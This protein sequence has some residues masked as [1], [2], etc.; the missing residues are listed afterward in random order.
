[1][2]KSTRSYQPELI[3]LGPDFY[4]AEEYDRCLHQ[5]ARIGRFLGGDRASQQTFA[6]LKKVAS[7]L[8]VGCGGGHFTIQLAKQFPS[9]QVVGIDISSPAVKFAKK[10]LREAR[11]KNVEFVVPKSV[12]LNYPPNSFDVVTAT[13]VC[14]HMNDED[15]VE[16]LKKSYQ[17]AKEKII[18]N[19]LHRHWLAYSG[20]ALISKPFFPNRLISQDGLL[21]IQRGF[22][23][24]EWVSY[25][26]AANIPLSCCSI[27]WHWAF[28]WIVTID[29]SKK[30]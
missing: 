11:V 4:T 23:K 22:K 15:L 14:H 13:L 1:M 28:R 24:K 9:A 3:D 25:L 29:T 27:K 10:R 8:D 26:K 19:D 12:K 16:F 18:I 21:S 7:I 20:F 6:K 30:S 5:L 2:K 17:I